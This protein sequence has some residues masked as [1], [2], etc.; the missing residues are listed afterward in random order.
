VG[1]CLTV[2]AAISKATSGDTVFIASGTYITQNISLTKSINLTGVGQT[3]TVLSANNAGRH[4]INPAGSTLVLNKL[5]IRHA[6]I[7]GGVAGAVL[8]SGT[9]AA[10]DVEFR[11]N[12]TDSQ[13]AALFN[14]QG[15]TALLFR[16]AFHRNT[17]FLGGAVGNG[18][19]II[20]DQSNFLA[21][22]AVNGG[23]ISSGGEM[24]HI[25]LSRS[26]LRDNLASSHGGAIFNNGAGLALRSTSVDSNSAGL[27]GG[28][29]H[30]YPFNPVTIEYSAITRNIASS[31]GAGIYIVSTGSPVRITNSTV[32]LN[33]ATGQG[34]GIYNE[35]SPLDIAFSTI[36]TNNA[37]S[38]QAA[39]CE[40]LLAP[41]VRRAC[42]WPTT[43]GPTVPVC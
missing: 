35:G 20:V 30:A 31:N 32:S 16:T 10:V 12:Q 18:G 3:L 4:F 26:V 41:R 39:A 33:S 40:W 8:N 24:A 6:D 5:S 42:C 13:G 38:A 37:L 7:G 19:Y 2:G 34:G 25:E 17:A 15:A 1:P 9:F 23:A 21:N 43:P 22:E 36:A 28:G 14:M 29:I 27:L 11:E